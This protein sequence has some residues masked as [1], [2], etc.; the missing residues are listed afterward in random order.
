MNDFPSGGIRSDIEI[1][2]FLSVCLFPLVGD[3]GLCIHSSVFCVVVFP[4]SPSSI[5]SRE[6]E[7][8]PTVTTEDV[9]TSF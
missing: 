9:F 6:V 2:S 5:V 7:H 4:F 8:K 1:G 3:V